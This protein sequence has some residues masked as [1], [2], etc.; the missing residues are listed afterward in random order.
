MLRIAMGGM[1]EETDL[2]QFLTADID[3]EDDSF[4]EMPPLEDLSQFNTRAIRASVPPSSTAS[5][6]SRRSTDSDE[7][8]VVMEI[9]SNGE[10]PSSSAAASAPLRRSA[11]RKDGARSSAVT[12]TAGA[13]TTGLDDEARAPSPASSTSK[14]RSKREKLAPCSRHGLV[15]S[16]PGKKPCPAEAKKGGDDAAEPCSVCLEVPSRDQETKLNGKGCNHIFCWDCIEKWAARENTCPLCKIRFTK[17]DRVH[18]S[19]QSKKRKKRG[20]AGSSGLSSGGQKS[21]RIKKR[22]QRADLV[23][24]NPLH[25]L[26]ESMEATGTLPAS[27]AQLLFGGIPPSSYAGPRGRRRP[28]SGSVESRSAASLSPGS[29]RLSRAAASSSSVSSQPSSAGA[30][31]STSIRTVE[32]PAGTSSRV[33]ITYTYGG[34]SRS[35]H[36]TRPSQRA[37]ETR[38]RTSSAVPASHP[39]D[40]N[41]DDDSEDGLRNFVE[42]VRRQHGAI[43]AFDGPLSMDGPMTG[44]YQSALM[45]GPSIRVPVPLTRRNLSPADTRATAVDLCESDS[46]GA[47]DVVLID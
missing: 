37:T 40:E 39:S 14:R 41:P 45:F 47:D 17:I 3:S 32:G 15:D 42:R 16:S 11:R 24:S 4:S 34:V 38:P 30:A 18:K 29:N 22:D 5:A 28:L 8:S 26:F 25:S 20:K 43:S 33:S 23:E 6:A 7:D 12:A 9:P 36:L 2:F 1:P 13:K 10:E 27:I 46:D 31:R 21:K 44:R 35:P 19:P